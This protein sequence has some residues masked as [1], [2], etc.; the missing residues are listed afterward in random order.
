MPGDVFD[1]IA[2]CQLHDVFGATLLGLHADML[3]TCFYLVSDLVVALDSANGEGGFL[4]PNFD[5]GYAGVGDLADDCTI[6][7]TN[8]L[9]SCE[10]FFIVL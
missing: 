1:E 10:A 5:G 7:K 2:V 9:L 3:G 4:G 8:A 6:S